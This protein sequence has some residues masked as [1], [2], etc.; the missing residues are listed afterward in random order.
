MFI[1]VP[2][3]PGHFPPPSPLV[4]V[5][6]L[7]ISM[8]LAVLCLLVGF[9]DYVPVKGEIIWYLPLT[10]WLISLSIMLSGSIHSVAKSRSSSF[11]PAA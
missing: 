6:L 1:Y 2:S 7:S 10:T 9:V 4:T 5:S 11:L 3:F 8:S